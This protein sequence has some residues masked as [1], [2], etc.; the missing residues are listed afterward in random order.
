MGWW[1]PNATG[2]VTWLQW[3]LWTLCSESECKSSVL[4]LKTTD[5]IPLICHAHLSTWGSCATVTSLH[6]ITTGFPNQLSILSM[7][8]PISSAKMPTAYVA[9]KVVSLRVYNLLGSTFI[10]PVSTPFAT[11]SLQRTCSK[12][13]FPSINMCTVNV[14]FASIAWHSSSYWPWTFFNC[15]QLLHRRAVIS[16]YASHNY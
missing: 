3:T 2:L 12:I 13:S 1:P 7:A 16:L 15:A 4:W 5:S 14:I 6:V 9:N 11:S 8:V 10:H